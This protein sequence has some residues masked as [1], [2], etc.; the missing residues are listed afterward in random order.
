MLG[1]FL[2]GRFLL[3]S[4]LLGGLLLGGCTHKPSVSTGETT[5]VV[6]APLWPDDE[7]TGGLRA[8]CEPLPLD[9]LPGGVFS[10]TVTDSVLPRRAPVPTNRGERLVFA[11]LYETLVNVDCQG[12]ASPG[13]AEH[14][15]CT[16][17]S[18]V[19]VFSLRKGARFWDG[20]PVTSLDVRQAWLRNQA[21]P[22]AAGQS[23]P[24]AWLD[25]RERSVQA[26]DARRL[27]IRL[28][29]PQAD[30]PLLLAHPAT[31][32]A[33]ERLGWT[34][35]VGSGPCRLQAAT[36]APL[37]DLVCRPNVH[38]PE[39]PVWKRLTIFARPGV[40]PRD[41][42][43]TDTDLF[44]VRQL[45]DVAF[46][47]AAPGYR[48]LPLPWDRL[49][50][51]VLP[52]EQRDLG[53][54][55]WLTAAGRLTLPGDITGVSTRT[56]SSLA[57]PGGG[58]TGCPQLTG[59][60]TTSS[61]APLDW[62]LADQNL[63]ADVV[64]YRADDPGAR[65]LAER[66]VALAGPGARVASLRRESFA[67]ALQ[68]QMTGA[69]V[70]A[71]DHEFPSSCLQLASLL[72]RAAWLQKA[73]LVRPRNLPT[74]TLAAAEQWDAYDRPTSS[75]AAAR[76]AAAD[77]ARPLA[78]CRPWLVVRGELAGLRLDYDGTPLLAGL[79]RP[80]TGS[81]QP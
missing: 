23:S 72:G 5:P 1:G 54:G 68:W 62:E 27:S 56:W 51:L 42:V 31:A 64:L 28:P 26:L 37:P 70:L 4:L 45:Q 41:L 3:G 13:L 16:E 25:V 49:Y 12:G 57:F 14:W 66:L 63:A 81:L 19:W 17:D 40:D 73:A 38:H 18:T 43:A 76:L 34:W 75:G 30:F 15:A 20:T 74:E 11:Q 8:H 78:L 58:A 36:P 67:F 33:V 46:Y 29:E 10:V 48:A 6:A 2:L 35:P 61:A 71:L 32:V 79:G 53:A 80:R 24:W 69:C 39:P 22:R 52:P 44:V 47:D 21:L 7:E 9:A 59:P 65:E 55:R 77:V 50:L 60:V